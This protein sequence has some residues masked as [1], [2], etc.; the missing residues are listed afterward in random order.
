[1][2]QSVGVGAMWDMAYGRQPNSSESGYELTWLLSA[3]FHLAMVLGR[4][5]LVSRR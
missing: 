1:M 3:R 2:F 4:C 5:M